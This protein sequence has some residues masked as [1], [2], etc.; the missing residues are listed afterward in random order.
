MIV[1][2][3]AHRASPRPPARVLPASCPSG[4]V[5]LDLDTEMEVLRQKV[6]S[7]FERYIDAI[8]RHV[9]VGNARETRAFAAFVLTAIQGAWIRGRAD[10]S[11]KSFLEADAW[12]ATLAAPASSGRAGARKGKR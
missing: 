1:G 6:A 2:G 8:A 7:T 9:E 4:A 11:G 10:R 12:L 3:E 5:C